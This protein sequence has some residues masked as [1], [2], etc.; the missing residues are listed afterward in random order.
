MAH[1]FDT[2]AFAQRLRGAGVSEAQAEAH[3]KAA[4]DFVMADLVTKSDL[5]DAP[6]PEPTIELTE[7]GEQY[8]IP[9]C[10]RDQARGPKQARLWD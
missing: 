2:L 3:A 1:A 10:G 8:V 7:I 5:A 6:E 9:G 4:R